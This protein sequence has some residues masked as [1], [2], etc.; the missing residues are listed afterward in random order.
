MPDDRAVIW[1]EGR[2]HELRGRRVVGEHVQS[3][4]VSGDGTTFGT[5]R[6]T[7]TRI[8]VSWHLCH[9]RGPQLLPADPI[10]GIESR[11]VGREDTLIQ[12]HRCA[13]EV[14]TAGD[15]IL[16][17][18]ASG[19]EIECNQRGCTGIVA[20]DSLIGRSGS[21]IHQARRDINRWWSEHATAVSTVRY[22]ICSPPLC[23]ASEIIGSQPP[24]GGR[25]LCSGAAARNYYA[26]DDDR[27]TPKVAQVVANHSGM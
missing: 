8:V 21:H 10:P 16:P 3:L 2:R 22:E 4:A 9:W 27:G 15:L 1:R 18:N 23:A 17:D 11:L 13:V 7:K 26:V 14:L 19:V 5:N 20:G 25:L 12:Q 24:G 6:R